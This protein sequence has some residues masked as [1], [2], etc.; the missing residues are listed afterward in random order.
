VRAATANEDSIALHHITLHYR[1]AQTIEDSNILQ[2]SDYIY[3]INS[4]LM[5]A[6]EKKKTQFNVRKSYENCSS[7]WDKC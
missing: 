7:N 2:F 1:A 4:G 5:D 3:N 6:R